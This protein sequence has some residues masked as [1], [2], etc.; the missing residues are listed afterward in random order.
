MVSGV[1]ARD[2]I[3]LLATGGD[4]FNNEAVTI[5]EVNIGQV[6]VED[7]TISSFHMDGVCGLAFSGISSG[8]CYSTIVIIIKI[9]Y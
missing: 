5:S 9:F 3:T 8:N 6:T 4:G 1:V 7:S 2:T